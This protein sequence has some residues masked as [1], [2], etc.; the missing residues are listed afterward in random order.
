MV[1][2]KPNT[3]TITFTFSPKSF[4]IVALLIRKNTKARATKSFVN[5]ADIKIALRPARSLI[6]RIGLPL[7]GINTPALIDINPESFAL[8]FQPLTGID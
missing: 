6:E 1:Q 4:I 8:I 7:S 3:K 2:R 5:A